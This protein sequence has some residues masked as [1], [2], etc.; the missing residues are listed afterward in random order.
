MEP[1]EPENPNL[2]FKNNN[3]TLLLTASV[4]KRTLVGTI[5]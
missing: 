5:K 2:L 4:A 1:S 3:K